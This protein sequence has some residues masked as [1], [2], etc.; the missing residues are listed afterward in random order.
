MVTWFHR[1][2]WSFESRWGRRFSQSILPLGSQVFPI[3][4]AN[5]SAWQ[6]TWQEGPEKSPLRTMPS[7]ETVECFFHHDPGMKT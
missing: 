4:S 3:D 6:Q 1:V 7:R 5:F 2:S